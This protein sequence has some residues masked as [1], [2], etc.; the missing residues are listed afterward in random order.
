M[1]I[2]LPPKS[3][4]ELDRLAYVFGQLKD[5]F[6][7]PKGVV[8]FTPAEKIEKNEAFAG[9]SKADSFKLDSW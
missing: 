1:G 4:T 8:K 6:A 7:V 9:L 2:T 3:L 5:I